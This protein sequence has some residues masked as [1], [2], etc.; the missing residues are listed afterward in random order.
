VTG[1]IHPRE[2]PRDD[3]ARSE[4]KVWSALRDA[5]PDGWTAWH[6][7]RLRDTDNVFL[8]GDFVVASPTF[9]LL[10]LEVKGGRVELRD[11]RW[12]QND[13]PMKKPP[14]R[15]ALDF[16]HALARRLK[17]RG[18]AVPPFGAAVLFPECEFSA[19]PGT[20]DLDGVV[21]GAQD[22]PYLADAIT[23]AAQRA[24]PERVVPPPRPWVAEIGRLWG[25]QWGPTLATSRARAESAEQ[26]L[27][28]LN[29][30]QLALLDQTEETP[31]AVV[32][33]AAGTGKS[34]LA[35]ELCLRRA[36][37]GQSVLYLCFTR[38]LAAALRQDL[39]D[40]RSI[41][42]TSIRQIAFETLTKYGRDVAPQ[43]Q[44][45][46]EEASFEAA[47]V[48]SAEP[49]RAADLVVVD[50]AQDFSTSDWLL[51]EQLAR[52]AD[53]WA[54][55]DERQ[56]F[57][58]ERQFPASL[59]DG[60]ARL[61]LTIQERNPAVIAQFAARYAGTAAE[62]VGEPVAKHGGGP[63]AL[64]VVRAPADQL[65]GAVG[66]Q[67]RRWVRGGARPE[68]I[69]VVSLAGRTRSRL[70]G[71]PEIGGL[72]AIRAEDCAS[73]ERLVADTFLRIKGFERPFVVVTELGGDERR[74]GYDTRMYI[75]LTRATAEA[76]IVC[77]E[78]EIGHDERLA[79]LSRR[80]AVG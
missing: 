33:G 73:T 69:A 15:Q 45:F 4:V 78:A 74:D 67:V 57:W 40:S 17:L 13:A 12:L 37:R 63:S 42:A 10:V 49:A 32:T 2:A 52:D 25:E 6:S 71:L 34:L 21:L 18:V 54:F 61:K 29:S 19:G 1:T 72:P 46:W 64:R 26:R 59:F 28:R 8:E 27:L 68:Q 58:E 56:R 31:R 62:S 60:A 39:A 53:V 11:G 41:R 77:T 23:A 20:G 50:E 7:L 5:L 70:L 3:P 75:A 30:C 44:Q 66:E 36:S 55:L 38:P 65:V 80:D 22:L 79:G 43:E 24:V 51:V 14:L 48:L 9:G 76:A 35:R 47:D 16:V